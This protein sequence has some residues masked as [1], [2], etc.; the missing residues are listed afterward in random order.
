MPKPSEEKCKKHDWLFV[1]EVTN[2]AC[3]SE[4]TKLAGDRYFIC[5]NNVYGRRYVCAKCDKAKEVF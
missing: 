2:H 3:K 5:V 4:H 1:S